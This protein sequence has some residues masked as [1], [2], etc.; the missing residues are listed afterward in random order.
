MRRLGQVPIQT[1]GFPSR[2]AAVRA[3]DARW[4]GAPAE[5]VAWMLGCSVRD[6][7]YAR[8]L[9]R[10]RG[11]V[12]VRAPGTRKNS[13]EATAALRARRR[14]AGVCIDCADLDELPEPD[15]DRCE[16]CLQY[17][18]DRVATYRANK[19]TSAQEGRAS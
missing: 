2:Q 19:Q 15:K 17:I 12:K 11:P 7:W 10:H 18:R 9:D 5:E 1:A 6:I 3:Y 4:P 16:G 13:K 14:E 8:G